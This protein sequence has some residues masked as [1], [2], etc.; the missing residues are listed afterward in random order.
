M[1]NETVITKL[2]NGNV[3]IVVDGESYTLNPDAQCFKEVDLD[4]V[5]IKDKSSSKIDAFTVDSVEKVIREDATEV[6]INDLDTLFN[7][8]VNFFFFKL[9]GG[10]GSPNLKHL[11]SFDDFDDLITQFPS[12][13]D[14]G[15]L[16]YVLN[17][18]GTKWLPGSF[19]GT[20][21][22]KGTYAW[23]GSDWSSAVDEIAQ[24]LEYLRAVTSTVNP[25][26]TDDDTSIYRVG[27]HWINTDTGRLF[28]LVALAPANAVW[29]ELSLTI[30]SHDGTISGCTFGGGLTI[31]ADPTKVDWAAGEGIIINFITPTAPPI[32]TKVTWVEQLAIPVD[33]VLTALFTQFYV[34]ALGDLKQQTTLATP[35]QK[36][37]VIILDAAVHSPGFITNIATNSIQSYEGI[38]A[39][40]DYV[41]KL[42][43][44]N[45]GNGYSE[46]TGLAI[47]KA[48]GT[49]TLPWINRG[50]DPQ[51]PTTNNN[52]VQNPLITGLWSTSFR[53]GSN[54][55][56]FV[57][58]TTAINPDVLDTNTGTL[59][60]MPNNKYQNIR[61]YF[62]GQNNASVTVQGQQS[63]NSLDE[64]RASV[65]SENPDISPLLSTGVFV[66]VLSIKEGTTNIATAIA[67]GT[68]IFQDITSQTSAAAAGSGSQ[69]L[70]STYGF[71]TPV[72]EILLNSTQGAFTLRQA[73]GLNGSPAFEILDDTGAL[74]ASID[75][76]GNITATNLSN[77]D[78]T[79]DADKE[80]ST[81]QQ[82]ALDGKL[83][84]NDASGVKSLY[85]SNANTNE[86]SD[87]EKSKL[88]ALE[89]SKF[90][91]EFI[92]LAALQLAH[93]S[94]AVG[95]YA[96]VD[97]GIGVDVERYIW[98]DTDDIYVLQLGVSTILTD[99]QIKTQ[100][101]N[102]ANTNAFTDTEKTKLLGIENNATANDTDANLKNRANHTGTQI[103]ATI[104][105]FAASVRSVILT[106]ISF[107]SSVPITSSDT[108]LSA[109]G[110]LQAQVSLNNAKVTR[111]T[112]S[113]TAVIESPTSSEDLTFFRTDVAITVQEVIAVSVGSSPS[114]T[115]QLKHHTDRNNAG[116]AL[117]TSSSTTS[118]T[119]GNAATLSDATIPANSW[120]WFESTAQ[121]GTVD[122]L[123]IDIR[124]TED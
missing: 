1:A 12:V 16:A 13:P 3:L 9:T 86:Y 25:T 15:T 36:R 88:A 121:S 120:V 26:T 104:S 122:N 103:A 49:T 10:G 71:S 7:E 90:L 27:K 42:G 91:G 56:T 63:Y 6:A 123:T 21:Y 20:F 38:N 30:D 37:Q 40:L 112:L 52:A 101:E 77:I 50:V 70:Q 83:D 2:S 113:K 17:S 59:T 5:V 89:S 80:V 98:D 84:D 46:A 124:F 75:G 117:T 65:F 72:P 39:L 110:K 115:Y 44:I 67:G 14:I 99:A 66:T 4:S 45:D 81:A 61:F 18:Q 95:S 53:D 78:N 106:G 62:F 111:A 76:N 69:D 97:T 82:T 107:V 74:V 47:Q 28:E 57:P 114:V 64:A 85:E 119:T 54:G 11:G 105:D 116:N 51:D 33:D 41:T 93:P 68:A 48:A 58:S 43:P 100:Y 34:D 8:L 29:R 108:V 60:A 92:S 96:N 24:E 32:I 79:S 31:N 23:T 118:T 19:L 22:S 102:N 55:H 109:L 87:S 94:P 35:Q 73:I